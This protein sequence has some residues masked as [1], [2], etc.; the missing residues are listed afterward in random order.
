MDSE[1]NVYPNS[2]E[3]FSPFTEPLEQALDRKKEKAKVLE[4][5]KLSEEMLKHF[6]ERLE[7]YDSVSSIDVEIRE[8]PERFM[9]AWLVNRE[10][11]QILEQERNW[12][13]GLVEQ[14]KR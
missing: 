2:G 6:D 9:R 10:I 12:L 5:L 8:D 1:D 3:Y 11:V 7:F 14:Y 4:A 13:E